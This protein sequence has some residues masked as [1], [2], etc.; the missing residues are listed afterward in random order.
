MIR[1]RGKGGR[2]ERGGKGVDPPKIWRKSTPLLADCPCRMA[3]SA[4]HSWLFCYTLHADSLR[5]RI[6]D[7][8]NSS[9]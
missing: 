1:G 3:C 7:V 5:N 8:K 2:E 6:N 4:V 9:N